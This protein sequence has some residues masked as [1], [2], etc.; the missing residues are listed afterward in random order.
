MA[1]ETV[2]CKKCGTKY[3]V[4]MYGKIKDRERRVEYGHWICEDC[5]KNQTAEAAEKNAAAGLPELTGSDKQIAWAEKIRSEK[6]AEIEKFFAPLTITPEQKKRIDEVKNLIIA[7]AAAK[8]WIENRNESVNSLFD[9]YH[10][11]Q[12]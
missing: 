9:K 11:T 6:I 4:Q 7:E 3:D 12:Q 10:K 1:W 8:N 5:K 2:N